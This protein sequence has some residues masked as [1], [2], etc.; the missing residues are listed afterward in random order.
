MFPWI[1]ACAGKANVMKNRRF[2]NA[3]VEAA[4]LARLQGPTVE[5]PQTLGGA[6]HGGAMG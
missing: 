5:A 1:P 6:L 4:A 2:A 3:P